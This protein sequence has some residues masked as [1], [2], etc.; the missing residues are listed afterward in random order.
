MTETTRVALIAVL[1]ALLAAIPRFYDL[2]KL[3]FYADEETT[4]FASRSL[5]ESGAAQMPSG[6]PYHRAMPQ[7]IANAFFA[8]LAGTEKESS[9]RL[10]SALIGTLTASLIFLAFRSTIGTWPAFLCA[11]LLALSEWHIAVSREA[12]MYGP[13]L[14]FYVLAAMTSWRWASNG[15]WAML[16]CAAASVFVAVSFHTLAIFA[17]AFVLLPFLLRMPTRV[18]AL[19]AILF[20]LVTASLSY[21][22][23]RVFEAAPYVAWESAHGISNA[24]S[25][26]TTNDGGIW[27]KLPPL[28]KLLHPLFYVSS[29][30]GAGLGA[31]LAV[32]TLTHGGNLLHYVAWLGFLTGA[33][34]LAG[35]GQVYGAGLLMLLWLLCSPSGLQSIRRNL[36]PLGALAVLLVACCLA[37]S[38]QLGVKK[39]F[40]FPF[41]YLALFAQE[42]PL[43]IVVFLLAC[44]LL[45]LNPT[46]QNFDYAKLAVLAAL[47]PVIAIGAIKEWGGLRYVIGFYPFALI[48]AATGIS[49]VFKKLPL[50]I[51]P[52]LKQAA[53]GILLFIGALGSHGVVQAFNTATLGYGERIPIFGWPYPDHKTAGEYVKANLRDSDLVIAEDML[54]Q[55]WYAGKVDYWLRNHKTHHRPLFLNK[56]GEFRDIYVNSIA[57]TPALL[58]EINGIKERRIWLITS[59]ETSV[60]LTLY[61]SEQQIQWLTKIRANHDPVYTG[62]DALTQVFLLNPD[63]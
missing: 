18:N 45:A 25:E 10:F 16:G 1:L 20:T 42:F 44:A 37:V 35:L 49:E 38:L 51:A 46:K 22:Y 57:V 24:V 28:F 60:D 53:A 48:V 63:A 50:A 31:W 2:G 34:A 52:N 33:G 43:V 17:A 19:Q 23:S 27:D 3:G 5:A 9:Y 6:M 54:Q 61:L 59:A 21:A 47:M 4:S 11:L 55:R 39:I 14:F 8:K 58:E 56:D 12:R 7:T 13:F 26:V 15:G 29:L 36:A 62:R 30:L 32:R 40:A 41:A